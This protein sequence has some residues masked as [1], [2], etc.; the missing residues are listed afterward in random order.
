MRG[1]EG[2][3]WI[4]SRQETRCAPNLPWFCQ[5]DLIS[6]GFVSVRRGGGERKIEDSVSSKT[7]V[8][9]QGDRTGREK[10]TGPAF[11]FF[12]SFRFVFI[13]LP[14]NQR[15]GLP[16]DTPNP[17]PLLSLILTLCCRFSQSQVQGPP[18]GVAGALRARPALTRRGGCR[19]RQG[20]LASAG[21]RAVLPLGLAQVRSGWWYNRIGRCWWR[22][23]PV[24]IPIWFPCAPFPRA[25]C[26]SSQPVQQR[27]M[28]PNKNIP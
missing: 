13:G 7:E 25:V 28:P 6:R 5:R 17:P 10:A 16:P 14:R 2:R 23:R 12:F 21:G 3:G 15:F 8:G 11:F 19:E 4:C 27:A 20:R 1:G 24:S 26:L 18:P 9:E 22:V